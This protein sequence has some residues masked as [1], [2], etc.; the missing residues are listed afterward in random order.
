MGDNGSV[1]FMPSGRTSGLRTNAMV[2][3]GRGWGSPSDPSVG[4]PAEEHLLG[5]GS[6]IHYRT[7]PRSPRLS[8][9]FGGHAGVLVLTARRVVF[10]RGVLA[11]RF[12]DV[13]G[14][15]EGLRR[16]GGLSIAK[17]QILDA[18][19]ETSS[20]GAIV[21]VGGIPIV[22]QEVRLAL[23]FVGSGG[24]E[25]ATFVFPPPRLGVRTI[26]EWIEK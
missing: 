24:P 25:L 5:K 19:A 17:E 21:S 9:P 10:V 11:G 15:E 8:L 7:G 4:P 2:F 16:R 26:L 1:T 14:M 18:S 3:D 13:R 6:A 22:G 20:G 12:E 23:R